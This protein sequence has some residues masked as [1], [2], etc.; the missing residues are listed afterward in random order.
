MGVVTRVMLCAIADDATT[1]HWIVAVD[2]TSGA[3][4]RVGVQAAAAA[5]RRSWVGRGVE[6][7][8]LDRTIPIARDVACP[9]R[10]TCA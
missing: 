10:R 9:A 1:A 3:D 2:G 4:V 5:P 6:A 8:A 7:G